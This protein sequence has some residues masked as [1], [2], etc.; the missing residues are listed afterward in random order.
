MR[1]LRFVK[2]ADLAIAMS[3]AIIVAGVS[4]H[5]RI[6]QYRF[7]RQ[8]ERLLSDV[9]E[10]E[11][12][13]ADAARV[14]FVVRKWG[15]EEWRG[16]PTP[17]T[18]DDC[19]YRFQ[20]V[21]KTA[22][23]RT[24]TDPFASGGPA[25]VAVEW[26]GLRPTVVQAWLQVRA[27]ALGSVFF[28]LDTAGRGCN[29]QGGLGCTLMGHVGTKRRGSSWS[30]YDQADINLKHSLLHPDYLVGTFPAL[31]NVDT[32]GSPTVV[33]WGEFSSDANTADVSRL[34]QFDL[35][36]LTRFR[37]CKERHLLPTVWAQ[38]AEDT[39]ESPKSLTCT[40]ELSKRVAQLA[41]AIVVA[42]PN[43]VE[44][45]SPPYDGRAPQLR[46]LEMVNVIRKPEYPRRLALPNVDVD[47]A[48]PEMMTPADT[49]SAIRAS[50]EYVFLLQYR[51]NPNIGWWALYPCGALSFNDAS[52]AMVREAA[53]KPAD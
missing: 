16:P 7:R 11:L 5:L 32:G 44:L 36:C 37:S 14:R 8:A 49:G 52:L 6:E 10:L 27:N 17:C 22:L 28:S 43:S 20:L 34:M 38:S 3:V 25:T 50:Q 40:P 19:M 48:G 39:R 51:S 41:D 46:D 47:V 24:F 18:E 26:L 21:R 53:A 13:K 12:E 15:F 35:S 29:G 2:R 42:R 1:L 45:S 31:F 9:R 30:A 4:I 23:G 33:I